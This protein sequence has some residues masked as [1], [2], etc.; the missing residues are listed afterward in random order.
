MPNV[1]QSQVR[2]ALLLC[3]QCLSTSMVVDSDVAAL[4]LVVTVIANLAC[5]SEGCLL[6]LRSN[7]LPKLEQQLHQ[8]LQ[9]KEAARLGSLL[10]PLIHL[11]AQPEGQKQILRSVSAP[12]KLMIAFRN[13]GWVTGRGITRSAS[14]VVQGCWTCF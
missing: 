1:M 11:A 10:R 4:Q 2:T 5:T 7:L 3:A 13:S 9:R 12:G 8:L 6:L 14:C